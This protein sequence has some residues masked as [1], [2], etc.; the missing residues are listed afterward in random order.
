MAR[1][2]LFCAIGLTGG[3]LASANAYAQNGDDTLKHLP[4]KQ[5]EIVGQK[6]SGIPVIDPR[7]VEIKTSAELSKETGS[8][9]ISDA[10][11]AMSS[12]LEIR[13]YGP[14]GSIAL[15]SFRGLPPEYTTIYRDGIRLTNEQLGETDLGQLTLHGISRVE[16]I[17]ASSAIL[18]GGDAIGAAIDLVSEIPDSSSLRLGTEQ[19]TYDHSQGLPYQSYYLEA[20]EKVIPSLSFFVAGSSDHSTGAFPFF[21]DST[22]PSVVRANDSATLRNFSLNADWNADEQTTLRVTSN[23]FYASRGDPGTATTPGLGA[24]FPKAHQEDD[25]GFLSLQAKHNWE[26]W[27]GNVSVNYQSQFESYI[28]PLAGE[29]DSST[30]IIYGLSGHA[31]G[32]IA[33]WLHGYAGS[34]YLHTQLC[35][36]TNI[37]TTHSSTIS[38][39]RL[40]SYIAG[41]II[42]IEPLHVSASLKSEY[43]SDLSLFKLLPQA[44]AE[45]ELMPSLVLN[46]AYSRSFNAPTLNSLYWKQGGNPNLQPEQGDNWQFATGYKHYWHSLYAEASITYFNAH[47][48]N[49]IIWSPITPTWEPI[50]VGEV[51]SYGW[52]FRIKGRADIGEKLHLEIEESYTIDSALNITK[53]DVNFSKQLQYTSPTNSLF[54]AQIEHDDW[55]SLAALIR[56][57][58]HEFSDPANTVAGKLEPVTT[59]DLTMKSRTISIGYIGF[60]VLLGIQNVTDI[61]YQDVLNYPLPGRSY[62]FSIQLN[63]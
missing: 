34:D 47:I 27:T 12:S 43:I 31:D 5:V 20:T 41:L 22:H 1:L 39:D 52:E 19:T 32:Q 23:Y 9:L 30:N 53:S 57:R 54:I 60:F 36:S 38:R 35:G 13:R 6:E 55:G 21:Q 37:S 44:F 14:L 62:K 3:I 7:A 56:Y 42:P 16:L 61:Q 24:D 8:M 50:N 18:L 11:R 26:D 49:E 48:L 17:P 58:G 10:L 4:P 59:L 25:Q 45:Y 2:I 15:P 46:A 29:H 40:D 63:Y 51:R 28:D 33:S